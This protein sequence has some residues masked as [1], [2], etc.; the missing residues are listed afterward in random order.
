MGSPVMMRASDL[1]LHVCNGYITSVTAIISCRTTETAQTARETAKFVQAR[2]LAEAANSTIALGHH[3]GRT[4]LTTGAPLAREVVVR[5][6][7]G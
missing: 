6:C 7:V 4:P 2:S 5:V 1:P 3:D